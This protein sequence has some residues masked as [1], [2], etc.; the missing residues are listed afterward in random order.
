[1]E[2]ETENQMVDWAMDAYLD[3]REECAKIDVDNALLWRFPYRRL[4]AEAV[5]DSVLFV[6]GR[7][8]R[9]MGGPGVY[10]KIARAVLE[11]CAFALRDIVDRNAG[12]T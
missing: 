1:M 8:N 11:G 5:R 6:N 12:P 9:E 2:R 4:E 3:W 7:L 10:P